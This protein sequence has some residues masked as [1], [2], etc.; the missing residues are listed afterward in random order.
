MVLGLLLPGTLIGM[1]LTGSLP[2]L[3]VLAL[4]SGMARGFWPVLATVPFQLPDIRP[5][6][7]AVANTMT[8]TMTSAGFVLG[9]LIAGFLQDALGDLKLA[10]IILSFTPL[11][12]TVSAL[13]LRRPPTGALGALGQGTPTHGG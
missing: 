4:I 9:P 6:E 5:R 13:F 11:S 12:L 7:V 10:L 1:T 3:L 8:S 2:L